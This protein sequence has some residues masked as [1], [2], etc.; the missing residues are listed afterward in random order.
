MTLQTEY[1]STQKTRITLHR[2]PMYIT[3]D[4]FADYGPVVGVYTIK[5]KWGIASSDFE[6]LVTL[7]RPKFKVVPNIITF[8]CRNI[9][10]IVDSCRL[11]FWVCGAAEHLGN[12]CLIKKPRPRTKPTPKQPKE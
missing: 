1:M 4:H 9:F 8:G 2:V 7:T 6:V 5:T 10:V 3:E 12:L 11:F